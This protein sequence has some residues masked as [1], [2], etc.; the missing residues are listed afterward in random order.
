MNPTPVEQTE[1][2]IR[3]GSGAVLG[4]MVSTSPNMQHHQ[5]SKLLATSKPDDESAKP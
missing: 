5:P 4:V 1:A 2:R 3:V